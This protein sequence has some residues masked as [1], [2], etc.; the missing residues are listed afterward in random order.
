[1]ST[2]LAVTTV[3]PSHTVLATEIGLA[4]VVLL[5]GTLV[6]L[7]TLSFVAGGRRRRREAATTETESTR[8]AP[9]G[10]T[11]AWVRHDDLASSERLLDHSVAR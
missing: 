2:V 9:R 4:L 10:I 6:Y 8:E 7:V 3:T 11:E 1:M 5:V